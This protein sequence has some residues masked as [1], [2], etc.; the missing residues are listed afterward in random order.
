VL[1]VAAGSEHTC[2]LLQGRRVRCW[3]RNQYGQLGYGHTRT[4]GDDEAPASLA[5]VAVGGAVQ[6]IAAGEY[7]TCALRVDGAVRCWGWNGWGQLGT[8]RLDTVGD[9]ELPLFLL[10]VALGARA[11]QVAAGGHTTCALL[12]GGQVRCWGHGVYGQGGLGE[13]G[14]TNHRSLPG[15]AIA[16]PE[17][18]R[19]LTVGE[20]HAC[21]L[22]GQGGATCWGHNGTGQLGRGDVRQRDVPEP[23][24]IPLPGVTAVR[25][26]AGGGHTCALLDSGRVRCWGDNSHGQLGYGH[27]RYLGDDELPSLDSSLP[28]P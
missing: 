17:P 23:Q 10:P 1:E 4:L 2:A 25:L 26:A 15:A 16:L 6:S 20:L 24:P 21:A 9:D 27:T 3:G 12:E 18:A 11:L 5:D 8:G 28:N 13:A 22:L 7:H 14:W 19:S